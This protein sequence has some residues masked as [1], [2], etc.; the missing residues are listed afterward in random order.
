VG[1]A[2]LVLSAYALYRHRRRAGLWAL[3]A[4]L[5]ALLAMGTTL[6][7]GGRELARVPTLYRL[8]VGVVPA[9]RI[10]SQAS[11]FNVMVALGLAVLVGLAC[12]D[13]LARLS[14]RG[15]RQALLVTLLLAGWVCFE[16]LAV[17]LQLSEQDVPAYYSALAQEPGDFAILEMPLDHRTARDTMYPQTVHEKRLLNG[18]LARIS[19][20]WYAFL[21]ANM[22]LKSMRIQMP[23]DPA[24]HDVSRELALIAANGARYAL[25][26]K[27]SLAIGPQV[28]PEVLAYWQALLGPEPVYEDQALV[29]YALKTSPALEGP[30]TLR[31]GDG[32]SALDVRV[33]RAWL[34]PDDEQV[35]AVDLAWRAEARL[36]RPY[37]LTLSLR[38]PDGVVV[39]RQEN[40]RIVPLCPTDRWQA[41]MVLAERYLLPIPADLAADAYLLSLY[42]DDVLS[43]DAVGTDEMTFALPARAEPL[44][45]AL[46]AVA[47]PAS[48]VYGEQLQ[49]LGYTPTAGDGQLALDLAWLAVDEMPLLKVFVH[50]LAE[51]G[52]IVAQYDGMPRDW[53]YPTTLWAR[54]EVF[55]DRVVLDTSG[56]GP[57]TYRLAVGVYE[58]EGDRYA[59]VSSDSTTVSEGRAVLSRPIDL[60]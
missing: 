31:F 18:H 10:V 14:W 26:H 28:G 15:P 48:V 29:V 57:G 52:S 59:A 56:V 37:A 24:L 41:D 34:R 53:S 51:D 27:Q 6:T 54:G 30:P 42:V 3:T 5:F 38:G 8:L 22:A 47:Q 25:I 21:E 33:A 17:P 43:G 7:V 60:E 23:L 46:A 58:P 50:L 13:L 49:L 35:L 39:A 55:V 45:P 4:L 32:V 9:L 19:P 1:Y 44:V 2:V 40:L 20:A 16:F 12:A 36:D 11:R